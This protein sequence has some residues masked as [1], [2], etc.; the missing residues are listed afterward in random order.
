MGE[1]LRIHLFGE[2]HFEYRGSPHAFSAPP[3]TLP[4][5]AYL[6]LHRSAPVARETIAAA[7]WPESEHGESLANVRRHLHYLAKALPPAEPGVPWIA[8]KTRSVCWNA[9]SPYWLDVEVFETESQDQR[10]RAHAVRLYS[11]DLYERC[12]DEWMFFERERLRSVQMSNLAQL[13]ADARDRKSYLQALQYAQLMLALDP[14]REDALRSVI[15][16]RGL[17]GDH[18][19]ALAEYERFAQ[20]LKE[21]L[22]VAPSE[23]SAQLYERLRRAG[24]SGAANAA[25]SSAESHPLIG[26]RNELAMLSE[27]WHRAR[28]GHARALLIGGEAGVGKTT[29]LD[30]LANVARS[31]G[32]SVLRGAAAANAPYQ[33][34][35]DILRA[36]SGSPLHEIAQQQPGSG[37]DRLQFFET[38]ARLLERAAERPALVLIEDLHLAGAASVDLLRYLIARLQNAPIMF[39]ASY[40]E[41]EVDRAHPLRAMRR[42]LARNG[43]LSHLAVTPLDR[44]SARELLRSRARRP[45]AEDAL[46]RIYEA[47]DGNP[48][49]MIETLHQFA[50]S[51]IDAIPESIATI[52]RERLTSLDAHAKA[53]AE[54]AAVAGRQCSVELV[55]QVTGLR[56]GETLRAFEDLLDRHIVRE[57]IGSESGEF[58]FVHD[59]VRQSVYEQIPQ[60]ALRRRHARLGLVLQELYDGHIAELAGIVARHLELGGL[61]AAAA[62]M[63]AAAAGEALRVYAL[64]EANYCASKARELSVQPQIQARALLIMDSVARSRG[65][66]VERAKILQAL[67][68]FETVLPQETQT[69][70]LFRRSEVLTATS[71]AQAPQALE[72]LRAAVEREPSLR[73][74]FLLVSG[75]YRQQRGEHAEAIAELKHAQQ[76]FHE[77]GDMQG[78]LTSYAAWLDASISSGE[79][80]P[81]TIEQIGDVGDV[82]D[83]RT[84]ALLAFARGR[85]LFNYN[86]A[87]AYAAGEEMLAYAQSADDRWLEALAYRTMGC[88]GSHLNRFSLADAHLHRAADSILASGQPFHVAM[89]RYHQMALANRAAWIAAAREYAEEGIAAARACGSIDL[90]VRCGLN[91]AETDIAAGELESAFARLHPLHETA[92][93]HGLGGV[94]PAIDTLLGALQVGFEAPERG[95]DTLLRARERSMRFGISG[96][97]YYTLLGLAY[98]CAGDLA[99][100]HRC[101]DELRGGVAE[102]RSGYYIPQVYLWGC[103]QLLHFLERHD[104]ATEFAHASYER[105]DEMLGTLNDGAMRDAFLAYRFNRAIVALHEHGT[106]APD[107]MRSWFQC[108]NVGD[109]RANDYPRPVRATRNEKRKAGAHR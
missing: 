66:P 38:I 9:A 85:A 97:H 68:I 26:R 73:P 60:D 41:Y 61:D 8:A 54:A 23:D 56:E 37:D 109:M 79:L 50:Q 100:A 15:E 71:S 25:E 14:W 47:A 12:A 87:A 104:E 92:M 81:R 96:L 59:I 1:G 2:P 93:R 86:P 45:L 13:C 24:A 35:V 49:F 105:Y 90:E 28:Q 30:A 76:L 11:G 29:L 27:E 42:Q 83:P 108:W 74:R 48:L 39:A 31:E 99:A 106:W 94:Q 98:L 4:L 69:E 6:L 107:P 57:C 63:Y 103:A 46:E 22:G 77:R 43:Q 17:L 5:L 75:G 36:V 89:V 33:A 52:V 80:T 67:E 101:A 62:D 16:I 44:Q 21:E 70:L 88:S 65:T 64:E 40:R 20:R 78:V 84:A 55:S 102:L 72:A 3:K 10:Y 7:L 51:T 95:I 91:L 19:G 18:S 58:T 32:A 82:S 34:F 53:V